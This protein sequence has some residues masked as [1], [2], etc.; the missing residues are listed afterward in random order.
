MI[1]FALLWGALNG[2][3]STGIAVTFLPVFED[4]LGIATDIKLLELSIKTPVLKRLE[5]EAP[6]TYL[7][8]LS[9]AALAE[10]AA[11]SIKANPL[12]CRVGALYHDIGKISKP[13]YFAENQTT[14]SDKMRH[15]QL[16]PNMSVRLIRNHVKE[17]LDLAVEY[18]LPKIIADFIPQHHGTT[19]LT[20]FYGQALSEDEKDSVQEENYRYPGPKP[21]IVESAILMLAD[22]IEAASRTLP[23]NSKEGEIKQFV[24]KIINE[25]FM[26]GQFDECYLTLRDLHT[27]SEAFAKSVMNQM[28][29]RVEYPKIPQTSN[30]DRAAKGL[31]KPEAN[32]A[33]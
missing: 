22:S 19:L 12:L 5:E 4:I 17:G 7:H 29:R 14:Q 26:D 30:P 31:V 13:M 32:H 10:A 20:Y 24:R 18:K 11:E 23:V 33:D 28:H 3:L 27:L 6:G 15:A 8:S 1:L 16:T 25:K 21:Q 9:V 2:I